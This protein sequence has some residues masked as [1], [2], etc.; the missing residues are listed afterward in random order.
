LRKDLTEAK[1]YGIWTAIFE[2]ELKYLSEK[3]AEADIQATLSG[4]KLK[5]P[6]PDY[7]KKEIKVEEKKFYSQSMPL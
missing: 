3:F 2:V 6:L 5:L 4:R 7:F 1:V